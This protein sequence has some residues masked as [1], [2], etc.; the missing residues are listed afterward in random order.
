MELT[1]SRIKMF[2]DSMLRNIILVLVMFCFNISVGSVLEN[3]LAAR[4]SGASKDVCLRRR[5]IRR[6]DVA[7]FPHKIL[8]FALV[9]T[10]FTSKFVDG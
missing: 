10:C 8:R 3:K 4:C 1:Q 5:P 2:W 9:K 7:L 6:P